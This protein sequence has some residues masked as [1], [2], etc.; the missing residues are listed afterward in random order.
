MN[1]IMGD[2]RC[3]DFTDYTPDCGT[4]SESFLKMLANCIVE[5]EGHRMLNVV[6]CSDDCEELED[7]LACNDPDILDPE[8]ALVHSIFALD[9]CGRLAIKLFINEGFPQV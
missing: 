5:Y 7:G 4:I 8:A 9:D 2:V 3:G 1:K 6:G